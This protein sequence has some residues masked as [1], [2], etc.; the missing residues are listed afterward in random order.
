MNDLIR[1]KDWPEYLELAR[2]EVPSVLKDE[3]MIESWVRGRAYQLYD[4]DW[5]AKFTPERSTYKR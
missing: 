3:A 5:H 4:A 2:K 1:L